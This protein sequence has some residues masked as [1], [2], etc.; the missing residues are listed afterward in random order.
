MKYYI[1]AGEASGDLHG[2]NLMKGLKAEDPQADFRFWGGS[3]MA[4]VG[5]TLVQDYKDGA[6]MGVGDVIAKARKL[7]GNV[8]RCERDI[9]AYK[10]DVVVLIDYPGFNFKIAKYAHTHG[11]RVYYYIAPKTWASRESRNRKLKAYVDRL[12]IVFPF[13]KEY[14][15]SKGIPYIYKG[16]PLIDAIDESTALNEP[17]QAFLSRH[18]LKDGKF[19]AILAGSRGGEISRT[20]PVGM[21]L[22]DKL[23]ALPQYKDFTFL[24]AGAPSRSEEDYSTHIG[25]RDYVKLIFSDT[26]GILRN[27]EAAMI[28]SG[29][30]S[31][32]AAL[33]GTPQVVVYSFAKLT[34]A[35]VRRIVKVRYI[36]LGNLIVD[37]LVFRELIQEEMTPSNVEKEIRR[38]IEDSDYRGKMLD[39]YAEIRDA[40]GKSGASNAV[41]KAMI[42]ELGRS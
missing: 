37:R 30:A 14:F 23:H 22:A 31:L 28:N 36:S 19:I 8:R 32:E 20:M 38:L 3:L 9:E 27:S 11:Y 13:E 17:R 41:A 40:L 33:I 34:M 18:G 2:S 4:S 29:T 15:E 21:A 35:I 10:P 16:N 1:I 5:G 6:V 42:E 24:V 12:F 7:L 26:Y 39:G 25:G